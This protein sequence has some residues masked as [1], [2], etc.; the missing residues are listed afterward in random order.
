MLIL[1]PFFGD[2]DRFRPLLNN[3]I[4]S[5]KQSG[6]R[7][8]WFALSD[9]PETYDLP[10]MRVEIDGFRDL[11]RPDQPFDTKGALVCAALLKLREPVLVL[12]ADAFL[13]RD[14]MPTLEPFMKAPVAMPIDHG[15]IVFYRKPTFEKPLTGIR[16]LCAGVQFFGGDV[17]GDAVVPSCDRGRLVAGYRKAFEEIIA[18]PR[19]PWEPQLSH[20]VEQYAWSLCAHRR[21]G[22][23][24]PGSM[25]WAPVHLGES[26]F[27]VVYHHYGHSKWQQP[28]GVPTPALASGGEAER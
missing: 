17:K 11:I 26:P 21:G 7:V 3:W 2:R 22:Q 13:V 24:L 18:M 6:C 25:N 9:Q 8:P 27:A 16:K 23:V 28:P 10:S 4:A 20:L 14:P 1:V 5:Y 15:A 12:D 19:L